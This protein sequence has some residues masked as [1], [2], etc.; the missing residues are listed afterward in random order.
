M[1]PHLLSVRT[2]SVKPEADKNVGPYKQIAIVK[3][4][5]ILQPGGALGSFER[6]A[7][8]LNARVDAIGA[9]GALVLKLSECVGYWCP[10]CPCLLGVRIRPV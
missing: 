6:P 10:R 9:G 1:G 3:R 8:M 2:H 7:F 5:R 4:N